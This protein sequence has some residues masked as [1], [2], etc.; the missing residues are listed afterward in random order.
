MAIVRCLSVWK[1]A[2]WMNDSFGGR[3]KFVLQSD[4]SNG[5][6]SDEIDV[7]GECRIQHN[8]RISAGISRQP[9]L[10]AECVMD[11]AKTH[12]F[13]CFCGDCV[14]E[15]NGNIQA[16]LLCRLS[17]RCWQIQPV[18]LASPSSLPFLP[19]PPMLHS[20]PWILKSTL[21]LEQLT[22]D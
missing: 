11:T 5:V 2:F 12:N 20:S 9:G 8:P 7:W 18:V 4:A 14:F 3:G 15:F 17:L 13:K 19:I 22:N 21:S 16:Y 10:H 1:V 6:E